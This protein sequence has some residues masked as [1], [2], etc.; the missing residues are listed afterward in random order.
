MTGKSGKRGQWARDWLRTLWVAFT[1][2]PFGW[3]AG[4]GFLYAGLR[5]KRRAWVVAGVIYLLT[6]LGGLALVAA[7]PDGDVDTWRLDVGV[8]LSLCTWGVAVAHAFAIR[9]AYLDRVGR[10]PDPQLAAAEKLLE[11]RAEALKLASDDPLR[12]RELGVGRPDVPGAYDGGL[13][14][15]NHASAAAIG[16]LPRLDPVV[17]ERIVAIREEVD[18]FESL[19]DLGS[20]ASLPAATV[21]RLRGRAVC[22]PR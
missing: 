12:A 14:D 17:A 21:E 10:R 16:E 2:I 4:F 9:G 3:G 7:D 19:E 11:Q 15:V 1:F 13:V 8:L 5:A 22:L 20:L 18:G 6:G